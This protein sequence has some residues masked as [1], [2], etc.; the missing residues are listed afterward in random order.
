MTNQILQALVTFVL[1]GGLS[2]LLLWKY[3][4]K[5]AKSYSAH[6]EMQTIGNATEVFVDK[7]V[8]ITNLLREAT[9][10]TTKLREQKLIS[11][12][13]NRLFQ[14]LIKRHVKKNCKL[15]DDLRAEYK[16]ILDTY[17][18]DNE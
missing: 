6:K 14:D 11:D 10:E 4:R 13:K 5:N 9:E 1:G 3:K 12:S 7:L 18:I 16:M 2:A 8:L 15:V 17:G